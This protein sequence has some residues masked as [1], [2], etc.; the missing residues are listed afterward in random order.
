M[1]TFRYLEVIWKY[2]PR[3]YDQIDVTMT[4]VNTGAIALCVS[5]F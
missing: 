1:S 2:D 4:S 3:Y 5:I